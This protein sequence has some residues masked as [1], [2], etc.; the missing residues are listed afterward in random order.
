MTEI[1]KYAKGFADMVKMG[2]CIELLKGTI[3][4]FGTED[5]NT[6]NAD[7]FKHSIVQKYA[8]EITEALLESISIEELQK[9][10]KEVKENPV[11]TE[12]I[13]RAM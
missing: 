9:I 6:D 8:I 3:E 11:T 5:I 13:C 10:M 12:D 1:D 4:C 2:M 7:D